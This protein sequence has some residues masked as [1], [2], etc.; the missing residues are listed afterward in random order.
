[1]K[2]KS[3]VVVAPD[4]PAEGF[5]WVWHGEFFG[6][7]PNPD[8]AL[9]KK[10]Y[11]IVYMKVQ[12]LLGAPVAVMYWDGL[13]AELTSKYG[14]APKVDLVGLSRGGFYCRNCAIANP[15]RVSCIYNDAAVCDFKSW[16][17]GKG[18]GKGSASEWKRVLQVY[19]FKTEGEA[20]EYEGNPV[21]NLRPLVKAGVPSVSYTHLRAHET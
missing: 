4:K 19:E 1:M 6:H 14:F 13:Y 16:P 5:P 8:I 11:H 3:V 7:K 12:N 18:N 2:G 10:G 20:L 15:S 9:L 17:G 21:D